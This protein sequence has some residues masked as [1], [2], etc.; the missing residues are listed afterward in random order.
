M[1]RREP[2]GTERRALVLGQWNGL[3]NWA[4]L[5][6]SSRLL[7]VAFGNEERGGRLLFVCAL[8]W[9]RSNHREGG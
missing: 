3:E 4:G 9:F 6:F 8:G 7:A 5:E 1:K 2:D